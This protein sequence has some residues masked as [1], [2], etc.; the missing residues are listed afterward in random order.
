M[1][2]IIRLFTL[3]AALTPLHPVWGVPLVL[4]ADL[5]FAPLVPGVYNFR[6]HAAA[7]SEQGTMG[8]LNVSG[9]ARADV[10]R[11]EQDGP[12]AQRRVP[13]PPLNPPGLTSE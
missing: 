8:E 3:T 1:K 10:Y 7:H 13:D 6:D 4:K 9:P 2:T 12:P 11:S 5:A